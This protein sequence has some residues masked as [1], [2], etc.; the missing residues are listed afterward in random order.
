MKVTPLFISLFLLLSLSAWAA[1]DEF[2]TEFGYL[3]SYKEAH[4][5]AL[6]TKKPLMILFVTTSCPWCQKLKHQVLKKEEVNAL[7][8]N[9]FI[10]VM[11]DK[12]TEEFPKSLM[13]FAVPT[14]TF[15]E[16][17][18]EKKVFQIIGYKPFDEALGL[19]KQAKVKAKEESL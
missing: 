10:P 13:P 8:H 11:L 16:P 2:S 6:E 14:L 5:K 9:A 15:V 17:K 1:E 19:L 7:I 12:E 3:S 18:E 4:A